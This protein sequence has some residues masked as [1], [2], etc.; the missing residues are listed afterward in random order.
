MLKV[1]SSFTTHIG[2]TLI[3]LNVEKYYNKQE[4]E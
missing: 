2:T 4:S 1:L 3:D